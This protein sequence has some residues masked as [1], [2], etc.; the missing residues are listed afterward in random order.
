[1]PSSD[2][3]STVRSLHRLVEHY[4]PDGVL[5][6]S[7]FALGGVTGATLSVF[8]VG[9]GLTTVSLVGLLVELVGVVGVALAVPLT[10]AVAWPVYLSLIGNVDSA[11]AYPDGAAG[12]EEVTDPADSAEAVLKR[13]FAAGEI[14]YEEF[15]ARLDRI[16]ASRDGRRDGAD[17]DGDRERERSR[18]TEHAR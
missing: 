15:E 11:A 9:V 12:T 1:M 16:V 8:L 13:R 3:P 5:G 2:H 18:T 4:T 14:E 17:T 6:R 10:L 7:L